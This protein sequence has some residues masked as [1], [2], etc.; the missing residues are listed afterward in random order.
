MSF[1][2]I[3][4]SFLTLSEVLSKS[5]FESVLIHYFFLFS[6]SSSKVVSIEVSETIS[7]ISSI[8]NENTLNTC[9][10]RNKSHLCW[11]KLFLYRTSNS[12]SILCSNGSLLHSHDYLSSIVFVYNSFV[13]SYC[14]VG[15]YFLG[16]G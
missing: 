14:S 16:T 10:K 5:Y 11:N 6:I 15:K 3:F 2:T 12:H 7:T 1:S 9:M 4:L 8:G 13:I